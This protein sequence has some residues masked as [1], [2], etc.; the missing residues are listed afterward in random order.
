M[1]K[2]THVPRFLTS[3]MK[4]RS[5]G[6]KTQMFHRSRSVRCLTIDILH[7]ENRK[8]KRTQVKY[9]E[10]YVSVFSKQKELQTFLLCLALFFDFPAGIYDKTKPVLLIGGVWKPISIPTSF[11]QQTKWRLAI[12]TM[13]Q[14]TKSHM[15]AITAPRS[16]YESFHQV[17]K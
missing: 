11:L 4:P 2:L 14:S 7:A 6:D 3:T 17:R 9:M 5:C 8:K 1:K 12:D 13:G 16:I 15:G 10:F